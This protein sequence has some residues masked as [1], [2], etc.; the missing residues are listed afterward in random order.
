MIRS[1]PGAV[2]PEPASARSHSSRTFP[3]YFLPSRYA[4]PGC[5]KEVSRYPASLDER[6]TS[7]PIGLSHV[8][9][10]GYYRTR[11]RGCCPVHGS[12]PI[13]VPIDVMDRPYA[14]TRPVSDPDPGTELV[15]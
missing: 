4:Y 1:P 5:G 6:R 11:R 13:D 3:G 2:L 7:V 9:G 14:T 8:H 15:P 10:I 12:R